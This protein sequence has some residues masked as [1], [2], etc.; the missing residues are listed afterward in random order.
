MAS[1]IYPT[2]KVR[3]LDYL[4]AGTVK[5]ILIDTAD[6]T[7]STAHEFLSDVPAGAR[8]ATSSAL[9][10][11]TVTQSGANAV[12]DAADISFSGVTGDSSEAIILVEDTGVEAT[13]PLIAYIDV[14]SAGMPVTPNGGAIAVAFDNGAAKIFSI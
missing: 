8:I 1:V 9:G 11:K 7:Y 12:F 14:F 2:S 10:T 13:S 3:M 5:A 6:Y 4:V